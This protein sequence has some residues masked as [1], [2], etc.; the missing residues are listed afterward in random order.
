MNPRANHTSR[1]APP[2]DDAAHWLYTVVFD[3]RDLWGPQAEQI[4]ALEHAWEAA[5]AR[6]P[7]RQ[8]ITLSPSDTDHL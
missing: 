7:H 2:F 5:T 6:T 4:H 8:P 1:R 3:W